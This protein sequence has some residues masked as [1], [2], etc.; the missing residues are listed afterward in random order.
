MAENPKSE[1]ASIPRVNLL[2]TKTAKT[3]KNHTKDKEG[4]RYLIDRLIDEKCDR[5]IKNKKISMPLQ[6][7]N[8]LAGHSINEEQKK[9]S[10]G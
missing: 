7:L 8:A 6:I 9:I 5:L 3:I 2:G 4:R 1:K 10:L